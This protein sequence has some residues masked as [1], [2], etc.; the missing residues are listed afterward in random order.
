L[1]K[2][3]KESA[4]PKMS[5]ELKEAAEQFMKENGPFNQATRDEMQELAEDLQTLQKADALNEQV[6]RLQAVT[7]QQRELANRMAELAGK[8]SL[9]PEEQ[10]RADRFAKEQ[11]LLAQELESIQKELREAADAAD[12]KLPQMAESARKLAETLEQLAVP[13]EQLSAAQQAREQQGDAAH[14]HAESAARKLESLMKAAGNVQVGE[15]LQQGLDGPLRMQQQQLKN[16]MDQLKRGRRP[17]GLGQRSRG[18]G[19]NPGDGNGRGSSSGGQANGGQQG[20]LKPGQS[21]RQ[22]D[23]NMQVMGP[24]TQEAVESSDKSATTQAD[25]AGRFVLPGVTGEAA[26]AESLS[27]NARKPDGLSGANLRGVP[28]GYRDAAE[29]YFRRLSEEKSAK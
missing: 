9:T 10:A 19:Q 24:R 8:T 13:Q 28:V 17:P 2:Q 23:S 6:E 26:S 14:Q 3:Q 5:D 4:S 22:G 12:E 20:R 7:A 21:G 18:N 25:A 27:P 16:L 29:A 15:G 11:E 1:L